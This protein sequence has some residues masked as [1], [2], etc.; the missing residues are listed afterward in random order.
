MKNERRANCGCNRATSSLVRQAA[1]KPR[2]DRDGLS[3][4]LAGLFPK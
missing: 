3:S 1:L 4:L 2:A